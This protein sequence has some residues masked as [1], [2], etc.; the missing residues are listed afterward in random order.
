L[1]KNSTKEERVQSPDRFVSNGNYR[2]LFRSLSEAL[3]IAK[4]FEYALYMQ[5]P[6]KSSPRK[7]LFSS[8]QE[9]S[10]HQPKDNFLEEHITYQVSVEIN[11]TQVKINTIVYRPAV[12]LNVAIPTLHDKQSPLA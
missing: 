12:V 8:V 2:L 3:Q 6:S 1:V 10:Q 9:Q 5:L 7:T 11:E 4:C